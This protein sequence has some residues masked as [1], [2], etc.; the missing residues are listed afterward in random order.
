MEV[1][2]G[3]KCAHCGAAVPLGGKCSDCG[4]KLCVR[5]HRLRQLSI[6]GQIGSRWACPV[7]EEQAR[8]REQERAAASNNR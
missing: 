7:L 2:P 8:A 1:K 3:E 6:D 4:G 5:S